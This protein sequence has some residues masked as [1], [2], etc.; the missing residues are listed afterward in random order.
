MCYFHNKNRYASW[1]VNKRHTA[2]TRTAWT[3]T[4]RVWAASTRVW[5]T[6][7]AWIRATRSWTAW[8]YELYILLWLMFSYHSCINNGVKNKNHL[9]ESRGIL[10]ICL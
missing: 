7:T 4:G 10:I 1:R 3:G 2:R 9:Q 8:T 6:G 5:T